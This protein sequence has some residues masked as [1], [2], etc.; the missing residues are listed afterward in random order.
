MRPMSAN[1]NWP[2]CAELATETTKQHAANEY[3]GLYLIQVFWALLSRSELA[4]P[5]IRL[6]DHISRLRV[7]VAAT[8]HQKSLR[9][10][11]FS[12]EADL[13]AKANISRRASRS[14]INSVGMNVAVDRDCSSRNAIVYVD[15]FSRLDLTTNYRHYL[16]IIAIILKF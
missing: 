6:V 3:G 7:R 4:T 1:S 10:T 5:W 13:T 2:T 12:I 14:K 15:L 9:S 16:P 8:P 11:S